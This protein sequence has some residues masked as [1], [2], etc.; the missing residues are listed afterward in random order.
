[1]LPVMPSL[2]Q[3]LNMRGEHNKKVVENVT[4]V[5]LRIAESFQ[6]IHNQKL[7]FGQI[8]EL[9]MTLLDCGIVEAF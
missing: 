7:E 5:F 6:R 2:A 3:L 4:T 8:S 1:M 9:Y